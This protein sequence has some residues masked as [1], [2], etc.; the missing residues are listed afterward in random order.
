MVHFKKGD[1]VLIK[2]TNIMPYQYFIIDKVSPK[3][4]SIW[5][6]KSDLLEVYQKKR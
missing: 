6:D 2:R 5:V 3:K 1:R 4:I